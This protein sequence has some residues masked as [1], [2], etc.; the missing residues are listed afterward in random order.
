MSI[1]FE[2]INNS[3]IKELSS[4]LNV[5]KQNDIRTN[6][7]NYYN[8]S[9]NSLNESKDI[10]NVKYEEYFQKASKQYGVSSSLLKA[11]A[12]AESGYNTNAVSSCGAQG[13]MQLMPSTAKALGVI[14]AFDPE[15]N[16][17]GGAKYISQMLS[18]YNGDVKLALAAYNAG[19]GNVQKYGGVPP[20]KE[21]QNYISKVL[22]YIGNSSQSIINSGLESTLGSTSTLSAYDSE[23]TY[24]DII[25]SDYIAS[26]FLLQLLQMQN[27]SSSN[28][29]RLDIDV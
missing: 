19:P 14:N 24:D 13:V 4:R 11:I 23:K 6:F 1:N 8:Q 12:K 7:L 22:G 3:D 25:Q 15:Q 26:V 20:F 18:R 5:D 17:M 2:N 28:I 21:T 16:I 10:Q 27:N 9:I 29:G